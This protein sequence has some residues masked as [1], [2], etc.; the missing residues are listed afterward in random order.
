MAT[1]AC[2]LL[3]LLPATL[4]TPQAGSQLDG[5]V[6]VQPDKPTDPVA[7]PAREPAGQP[8]REPAGAGGSEALPGG[9]PAGAEVLL[10][11]LGLL[12]TLQ[13]GLPTRV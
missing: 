1:R 3:L 10:R 5:V 9:E 4:A 2:L 8:A 11:P 13:V 6:Q 12:Q 7:G